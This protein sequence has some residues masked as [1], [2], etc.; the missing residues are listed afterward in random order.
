MYNVIRRATSTHLAIYYAIVT[1]VKLMSLIFLDTKSSV[2]TSRVITWND[3]Q[4]ITLLIMDKY[5]AQEPRTVNTINNGN[6]T[7]LCTP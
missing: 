6:I 5:N 4:L 7:L 1:K 2:V 3:S